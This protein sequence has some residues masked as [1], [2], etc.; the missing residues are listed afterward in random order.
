M[1]DHFEDGITL[2]SGLHGKCI[3]A[4]SYYGRC[5]FSSGFFLEVLI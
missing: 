5:I 4:A 2:E 3:W 1:E